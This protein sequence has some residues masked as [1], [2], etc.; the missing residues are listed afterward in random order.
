MKN[1]LLYVAMFFLVLCLPIFSSENGVQW[2]WAELVWIPLSLISVSLLCIG[3]YLYKIER[4][5]EVKS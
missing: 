5:N 2:F 1:Y 3:Y 4:I